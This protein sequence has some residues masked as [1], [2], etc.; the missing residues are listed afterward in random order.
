MVSRLARIVFDF[1]R[2]MEVSGFLQHLS[3]FLGSKSRLQCSTVGDTRTLILGMKNGLSSTVRMAREASD[4]KMWLSLLWFIDV[5]LSGIW[6]YACSIIEPR[7]TERDFR[8]SQA[9]KARRLLSVHIVIRLL[10]VRLLCI[11]V[12]LFVIDTIPALY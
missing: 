9:V 2:E 11:I 6:N 7:G 5:L 8:A 3:L 12:V 1:F 10:V 4:W